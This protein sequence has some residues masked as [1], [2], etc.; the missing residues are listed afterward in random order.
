MKYVLIMAVGIIITLFFSAIG[1]LIEARRH[2][3]D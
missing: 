1:A 3:L 2:P